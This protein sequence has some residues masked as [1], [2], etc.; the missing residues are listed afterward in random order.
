MTSLVFTSFIYKD[1]TLADSILSLYKLNDQLHHI[2]S[3]IPR[4][5]DQRKHV[6]EG[7]KDLV[8]QGHYVCI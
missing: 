8:Y 2:V 3:T 1:G 7:L 4:H 5:F 6:Y